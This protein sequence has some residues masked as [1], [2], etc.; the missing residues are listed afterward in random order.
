MRPKHN[1]HLQLTL[2]FFSALVPIAIGGMTWM[3]TRVSPNEV[4][5]YHRLTKQLD[6]KAQQTTPY[7]SKQDRLKV[8]KDVLFTQGQDRLQLRLRAADSQ[9]V[10]DHDQSTEI[11]EHM[12]EVI[13]I[14]QEQLYWLLPDGRE[15]TMQ[16]NGRL[17]VRNA[18]PGEGASWFSKDLK[19]L[20]PMQIIRYLEADTAS[21][22]YKKDLFVADNVRISSYAVPGHELV[23]TM[24]PKKTLMKG[25]AKAVE[26][27][28]SGKDLNFKAHQLKATLFSIP[29]RQS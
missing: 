3:L 7:S 29:G 13:G 25:T 6:N 26:F 16:S 20:I 2:F 23:E 21:Y 9:L 12:H 22:H 27:S 14:M 8:Q 4:Q 28:L 18:N 1:R 24:D 5:A 10:L 17:L 19:G 15:A 11:V